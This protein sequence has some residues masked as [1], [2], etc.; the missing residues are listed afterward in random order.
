MKYPNWLRQQVSQEKIANIFKRT[1]TNEPNVYII[2]QDSSNY[3]RFYVDDD[4]YIPT[5]IDRLLYE[6]SN[7]F[8]V[9]I[10]Y[11]EELITI[12]NTESCSNRDFKR[13]LE[14]FPA[15]GICAYT[16]ENYIMEAFN[17]FATSESEETLA[18]NLYTASLNNPILDYIATLQ[19]NNKGDAFAKQRIYKVY[20]YMVKSALLYALLK[21]KSAFPLQKEDFRKE[22]VMTL[23]REAQQSLDTIHNTYAIYLELISKEEYMKN[24]SEEIIY[25]F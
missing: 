2:E 8:G 20:H 4:D 9:K 22:N 21:G 17:L 1:H 23:Y 25:G 6:L 19:F 3:I 18:V 12:S 13:L 24:E 14:I 10:D 16:L 7:I 15:N 11:S 5:A